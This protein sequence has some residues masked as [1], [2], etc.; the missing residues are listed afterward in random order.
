MVDC[1]EFVELDTNLLEAPSEVGGG[2]PSEMMV[3]APSE[4]MRGFFYGPGEFAEEG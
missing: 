3:W 2:P 4:E 1:G